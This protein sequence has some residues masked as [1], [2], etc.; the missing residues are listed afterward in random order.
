MLDAVAL[1][2]IHEAIAATID[3]RP[4]HIDE[5]SVLHVED[6]EFILG[7]DSISVMPED[8][9]L[10]TSER[11][12]AFIDTKSEDSCVL[13]LRVYPGDSSDD[14]LTG[15]IRI[16]EEG[17]RSARRDCSIIFLDEPEAQ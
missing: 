12:V 7:S 16:H 5:G 13:K 1:E 2:P 15:R 9:G 17:I 11:E 4:I 3:E 6:T 10:D 8:S 14:I